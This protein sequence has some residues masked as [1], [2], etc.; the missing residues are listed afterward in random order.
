MK[1]SLTLTVK[2]IATFVALVM[3]L[4]LI[5]NNP[6]G[7]ILW[8]SILSTALN[9]IIG[10]LIIFPSY[11]NITASIVDGITIALVAY[12]FSLF[13]TKLSNKLY[14]SLYSRINCGSF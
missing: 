4:Y 14:C 11:G 1:T 10:D 7:W 12:F 6:L 8:V 9:Y 5:D 2:F 13:N 3:T